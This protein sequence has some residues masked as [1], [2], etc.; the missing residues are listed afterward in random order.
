M[1][2][3]HGLPEILLPR[4]TDGTDELLVTARVA[5]VRVPGAG[6]AV[7]G[8]DDGAVGHKIG[9]ADAEV[10]DVRIFFQRRRVERQA[11]AG[12]L[13]ALC[14]VAFHRDPSYVRCGMT[15]APLG[16]T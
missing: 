16:M 7:G 6:V 4:R 9:V 11:A 1:I 5:V 12:V 2:G 8:V 3:G 13:K 15:V 14:N 10:N